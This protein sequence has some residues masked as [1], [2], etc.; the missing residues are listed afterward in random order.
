[1]SGNKDCVGIIH[2]TMFFSGNMQEVT[3]SY[4]HMEDR[5]NWLPYLVRLVVCKYK[6]SQTMSNYSDRI[7]KP[8]ICPSMKRKMKTIRL[9]VPM[10]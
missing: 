4:R 7:R 2:Y 3:I 6:S 8:K 1:M 5:T 9:M 10:V